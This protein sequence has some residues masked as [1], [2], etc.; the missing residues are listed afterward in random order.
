MKSQWSLRAWMVKLQIQ[1]RSRMF[2][3]VCHRLWLSE[4]NILHMTLFCHTKWFLGTKCVRG[5]LQL[6]STMY[7]ALWDMQRPRS[8]CNNVYYCKLYCT[9]WTVWLY[10]WFRTTHVFFKEND[11]IIILMVLNVFVCILKISQVEIL[12]VTVVKVFSYWV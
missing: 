1:W 10:S 12:I 8:V 9:C 6:S 11:V 3:S 7:L 4:R 5:K 2:S